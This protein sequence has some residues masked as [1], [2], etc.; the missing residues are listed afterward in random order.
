MSFRARLTL[1]AAAAV[2][3]A[4]ILASA[5]IYVLVRN[6]LRSTVDEGLRASAVEIAQEPLSRVYYAPPFSGVYVQVAQPNGECTGAARR[7]L[8]GSGQPV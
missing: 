6:Q 7:A 3:L 4:V 5:A 8:R 1:A 2:A